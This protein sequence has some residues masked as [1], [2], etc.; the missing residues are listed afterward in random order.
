MEFKIIFGFQQSYQFQALLTIDQNK[1][2]C[3]LEFNDILELNF[4]DWIITF[5]SFELDQTNSRSLIVNG[6]Y[7]PGFIIFEDEKAINEA[8]QFLEKLNLIIPISMHGKSFMIVS[9]YLNINN[10]Y[11]DYSNFHVIIDVDINHN[12][13]MEGNI[14]VWEKLNEANIGLSGELDKMFSWKNFFEETR[15][16]YIDEN[17]HLR[18]I[19]KGYYTSG[20]LIFD[21][22]DSI[23]HFKQIFGDFLKIVSVSSTGFTFKIV[24]NK[25][26]IFEMNTLESIIN[27]QQ[28]KKNEVFF[29]DFVEKN[30]F[31][32]EQKKQKIKITNEL[33][34]IYDRINIAYYQKNNNN[35]LEAISQ[36]H[37]YAMTNVIELEETFEEKSIP[38]ILNSCLAEKMPNKLR[39]SVIIFFINAF[40]K[41]DNS[42][43]KYMINLGIIP[44]FRGIL[45]ES[46]N[47]LVYYALICLT[48]IS[49]E[50]ITS[51]N[52]VLAII[53][54]KDILDLIINNNNKKIQKASARLIQSFCYNVIDKNI[55]SRL[56]YSIT[57]CL[58]EGTKNIY[59][60]LL[61]AICKLVDSKITCQMFL[62]ESNSQGN[63]PLYFFSSFIMDPDPEI[64]ISSLSFIITLNIYN[65][66]EIV[67]VNYEQVL[68][69]LS[70]DNQKV[71]FYSLRLISNALVLDSNICDL[72]INSSIFSLIYDIAR[73]RT[74]KNGIEAMFLLSN[75]V[76]KSNQ[77][78][79]D[80]ISRKFNLISLFT[81]GLNIEDQSL[82]LSLLS[83]LAQIMNTEDINIQ[84]TKY[85]EQFELSNGREILES[86]ICSENQEIS[87]KATIF[88][89]LFLVK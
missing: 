33:H 52:E 65:N 62:K 10:C 37:C 44:I 72:I 71:I 38:Q 88:E 84:N 40:E 61:Q 28:K 50:S 31:S 46:Y 51:K 58:M 48:N 87:Q 9:D 3:Y 4:I 25:K 69:L 54:N 49:L 45:H 36:L 53:R 75:L 16:I 30:G 5:F 79:F 73:E 81:D 1:G 23:S 66:D 80:I 8:Y 2:L 74:G 57:T 32:K 19:L 67:S 43:L 56:L 13:F 17:D 82:V 85:Q 59:S 24:L 26:R 47:N 64:V 22:V 20:I 89:R 35:L 14:I 18:L 11:T 63:I 15:E 42:L 27:C 6:T 60:I 55:F 29:N 12:L 76:Q 7:M 68:S 70:C 34:N 77:I 86:L 83:T 41:K 39:E 21:N 78:Q